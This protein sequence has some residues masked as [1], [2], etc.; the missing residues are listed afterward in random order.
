MLNHEQFMGVKAESPEPLIL[1]S[2]TNLRYAQA[3]QNVCR[4]CSS[5][6]EI[7]DS[8]HEFYR[9]LSTPAPRTCPAC[10]LQRRLVERNARTLYKRKCDLM[11]KEFI[12]PYHPDHTFPVYAPDVWWSDQWNAMDY[13]QAF[14]FSNPFFEQFSN[15]L[16]RVPH[17]GQFIVGGTV[18]N[19][20]YVNCA[21][22]L[23]DCYLV[24][25]TDYNEKCYYGNRIFH[26]TAIVDCSNCYEDELCYQCIDCQK[27]YH[28]LFSQ[29][30][31][32]CNNSYF[33]SDCIGCSDCIACINQRQKCQMIFNEQL[34]P[35]EYEVR[36]KDLQL[37]SHYGIE[38]LQYKA[39]AFFRTQPHRALHNEH[40]QNSTGNHLYDSKNAQDCFDCKDLED[41]VRC[42]RVFNSKSCMD[43]TS[44]GD[45]SELMYQCASSGD[46]G[47]RLRFCTT[48][49]T[50][51]VELEYSA[52]CTGCRNCFG[53]VGMR[54]A[55]YCILN[56]QYSEEEY[57]KIRKRIV[58]HMTSVGEYGEFFPKHLCPFAYNETIAMEYFPLTKEQAI[59]QG[60]KW[61]DDDREAPHVPTFVR[62]DDLPQTIGEISDDIVQWAVLCS[63]TGKPYRIIKQELDFYRQLNIPLP[64]NHPDERHRRR[65]A[66]RPGVVLYDRPC[67]KCRR[68]TRTTYTPGQLEI[69]Y[70]EEC[71]LKEVY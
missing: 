69:V 17:Q 10:R 63:A 26:N 56:R 34:S 55:Q 54:T 15:L 43:Y 42:A 48:C 65:I 7:L 71:Y 9:E 5:A 68:Q 66:R 41:C 36:K 27:C 67:A 23:K 51:N 59:E 44:W 4:D 11:G 8:D 2:N 39:D 50:N 12:S 1:S 52:H 3:M 31:Q 40:N 16:N 32:N 20:D 53:C 28:L 62:A 58:E 30:C 29:D 14:D 33:L 46:N 18:E 45:R 47:Y 13:G 64:R 21:G 19:S 6:Y 38:E 49:T 24:A 60:Y 70:C 25:E 35:E 37:D 61:R 22:Y 57:Q